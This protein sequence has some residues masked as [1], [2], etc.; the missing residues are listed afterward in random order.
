MATRAE[1]AVIGAGITG[2]CAARALTRRGREVLVL[3]QGLVGHRKGGSHGSCRIFRLG[4]EHAAY[5][6]FAQ[7]AR[8]LWADLEDASGERL[9]HPVPQLTFGPQMPEV[10]A[11]MTEAGARCELLTA[12]ETAERFPAVA[13]P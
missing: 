3:E 8:D 11:A 5:V 10:L 4:Y 7:R 1:F 9:L 13:A 2:L 6:R 12:A